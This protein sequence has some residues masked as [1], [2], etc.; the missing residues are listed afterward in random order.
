MKKTFFAMVLFTASLQTPAY[1]QGDSSLS[2]NLVSKLKTYLTGYIAEKTY[3]QFDKP[4]YAAGD[5]I[6]FKAYVTVGERRQLSGMSRVLHVDLI[7]T[8]NNIDQFVKLQLDNGVAWGDFALPDSLPQ[9]NYRVRAYTQW[10]RNGGDDIFF[11]HTIAIGSVQ[12]HKIPESG[13]G[14]PLSENAKPDIQF[15]PEGGNLVTGIRSKVAFKAIGQNGL[16]IN[17]KGVI[18]DNEN[19]EICRFSSAHL[20]MGYFYLDPQEG[21]TYRAKINYPNGN[22]GVNDLPKPDISGIV[23]TV[24]NDSIPKASV[25]IETNTSYFAKNRGKNYSLL[26]YDGGK[27]TTV[28]CNLDSQVITLNI[29]KRRLRTG[30]ATV[31]LFSPAVEPL[32]ERLF[33]VQNYDQLKLEVNSNK[34]EYATREKVNIQLNVKNRADS[35]VTGHFSVSVI[36]ES[37]VPVDENNES[38]ILNNLLLTS[39]LK[40]Y[41]EQPNYYFTDTSAIAANNLDVLM[42]TQG[43]RRF[44]WKQVLNNE[45]QPLAYQP[46]KGLEIR[47]I[48]KNLVGKPINKGQITLLTINGG[49]ILTSTTDN[50]GLFHFSNLVFMDSTHF[51]LSAINAKGKNLTKITYFTEKPISAAAPNQ[52][53]ALQRVIDTPTSAFLESD[54]KLQEEF[55]KYGHVKRIMLKEVKINDYRTQSLAGAGYADQVMHADEIGQIGGQLSTS[56]NGRLRGVGFSKGVPFLT[57]PLTNG[58]MLVIVDGEETNSPFDVNQ[59]PSTQIE[60]IEVLKYASASIYGV[61]GGNGVLVIT[62]KQGGMNPKDIASIGVLPITPKGF[63]KAREFY[64]PKY[65]DASL[66]NKQRDLRSTIYWNPELVTD[67]EGNASFDYYNA[68]RAGTYRIVI[69]GIDDKGNLGRQVYRYKVE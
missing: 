19:K 39:D 56:L 20:G 27:A 64:S 17:V 22:Q 66:I 51:V 8:K 7:N 62:T 61:N 46:E 25:R 23:L 43:Y 26:I 5:T 31:T 29:L 35:A 13:S 32:C 6:Y 54:K 42:L 45:L 58:P 30:I 9:G 44:T 21:K 36:D 59:I 15:F 63:Y 41:V 67:K 34:T 47:G 4:Y 14:S 33:F 37:K 40:G 55:E 3:L 68:D 18:V 11:D 65:G 16:G 38:T 1:C 57:G 60:T 10:M 28:S 48:V 52:L 2:K 12:N 69:E 53:K 24:N 50:D 49:S